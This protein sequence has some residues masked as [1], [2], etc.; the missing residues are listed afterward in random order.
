MRSHKPVWRSPEEIVEIGFQRSHVVMMNEAH[1]DLRRCIRTRQIGQR[2]LPVAHRVGVRHL[3]ME[4]L[5]LEFAEKCNTTRRP[6]E[7]AF[8]YLSQ[9][10]MRD[11]IQAALDLGW[12]L[13]AYECDLSLWFFTR[14]GITIS[15]TD[16]LQELYKQERY[17]Q[18]Q[19]Y[20]AEL[21]SMEFTNWREEQQA[22]NLIAALQSLPPETPLLVWC[23]MGHLTKVISREWIPM[24][25]QFQRLSGINPFTIDQTR[26][27]NFEAHP[28]PFIELVNQFQDELI[29]LN[30]TAGFL[31]EE[32][33]PAVK[34][35][36]EFGVDA[37]LL[38]IHNEM[39]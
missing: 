27:V 30:D 21:I 8:G 29:K 33:P 10:E 25:Y 15:I 16:D 14:H 7:E 6:P 11:F 4:A 12:T 28:T 20:E 17:K 5:N 23:G 39:E 22:R 36:F 38:S 37:F 18:L 35:Y 32:I 2:I 13:I 19:P 3:A 34:R 9:P 31:K 26:T 24:G 1:N